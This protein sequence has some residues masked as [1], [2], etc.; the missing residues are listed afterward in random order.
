MKPEKGRTGHFRHPRDLYGAFLGRNHHAVGV[1]GF[2]S[3]EAFFTDRQ[4]ISSVEPA[5]EF[6]SANRADVNVFLNF[7]EA[8]C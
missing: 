3:G 2:N 4:S 6:I 8:I 7:L 5:I 1:A